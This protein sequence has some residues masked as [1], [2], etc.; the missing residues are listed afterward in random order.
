MSDMTVSDKQQL[1]WTRT[2]C[3]LCHSTNVETAVPLNPMPIATPNFAVPGA[4]LDDPIYREPVPLSLDLCTDC[5]FVQVSN[6]GNP[7]LQYRDYVYTTSMSLG[8][9]EH[10]RTA[11]KDIV[12][13]VGLKPGDFVVECGSNDGTLLGFLKEHGMKVLG[14][15]PAVNIAKQATERGI[16]TWP[17]F[18][19][20]EIGQKVRAERGPAD[21]IVAN[22]IVANVDDMDTFVL[23]I[24]DA[25]A[26]TGVFVFE[27][28]YGVDVTEKNLLDT[29]YHEHLSYFNVKPLIGFFERHG[30]ELVDVQLIDTKGGSIRAFAQLQGGGRP[31]SDEVRRLVAYEDELGV[32]KLPYYAAYTRRI[33]A[34]AD[35]L[36]RLCDEHHAAGREVAGYGVSVGTTTLLSQF[37]LTQKIDFLCDDAPNK[38]PVLAGPGYDIPVYTGAAVAERDPAAIVVFAWRYAKPIM[39][40]HGDYIARGGDFVVPLPDVEHPKG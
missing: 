11:A 39:S 30:M 31:V 13:R 25:L 34:I 6:V 5:G 40:K 19:R 35:E 1:Y 14:V 27:T 18:F 21:A 4:S 9:T 16:E 7:E 23:G 2:D 32:D 36:N 29:V 28:Q 20:H 24:R 3:R 37:G 15:D 26:P 8:L 33:A 12:A 38:A 10:F 22:N 17:E